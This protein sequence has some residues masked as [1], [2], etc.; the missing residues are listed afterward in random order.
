M[1]LKRKEINLYYT[2]YK[3]YKFVHILDIFLKITTLYMYI[4]IILYDPILNELV[5]N[6]FVANFAKIN[7]VKKEKKIKFQPNT[8]KYKKNR[9][10]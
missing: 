3:K 9:R 10:I 4:W 6:I 7:K 1:Y 5:L 2:F 8:N